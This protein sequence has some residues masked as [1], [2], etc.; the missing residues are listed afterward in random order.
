[1]RLAGAAAPCRIFGLQTNKAQKN[2]RAEA[3]PKN[4]YTGPTPRPCY[5]LLLAAW[6]Q[7]CFAPLDHPPTTWTASWTQIRTRLQDCA[8]PY[9]LDLRSNVILLPLVRDKKIYPPAVAI[10]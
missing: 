8:G 6:R 7:R 5:R 9:L 10:G 3:L 1:M 4:S 2:S